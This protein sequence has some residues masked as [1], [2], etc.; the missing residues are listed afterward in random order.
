[1]SREELIKRIKSLLE[2]EYGERLKGVVLY[3]S[4]AR[5]EAIADSDVDLL[6][7]LG[8]PVD[9]GRETLK[10]IDLLY[11]TVLAIERPIHALPVDADDFR[12]GKYALYRT[13]KEEGLNL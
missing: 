5:G 11:D 2:A 3:G 10:V 9:W 12:A 13:V 4:E 6:V 7:L 1:M 8:G